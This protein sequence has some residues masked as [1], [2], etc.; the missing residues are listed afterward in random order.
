MYDILLSLYIG[1]YILRYSSS[2]VNLLSWNLFTLSCV[3]VCWE[4]THSASTA[5]AIWIF[6]APHV[7]NSLII[8]LI[9][10][11]V[12]QQIQIFFAFFTSAQ[13]NAYS[14]Q[15][16]NSSNVILHQIGIGSSK[17]PSLCSTIHKICMALQTGFVCFNANCTKFKAAN[18]TRKKIT[19]SSPVH[20]M[21]LTLDICFS[22]HRHFRHL[23]FFPPTFLT[24]PFLSADILD[25]CVF[26][27][28]FLTSAF[29][30]RHFRHLRF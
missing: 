18:F 4:V 16:L 3:V 17:S 10:F 25:I 23:R 26:P 14:N 28:T 6:V 15:L 30:R 1:Q 12:I 8:Q 13:N 29:F 2:S 19:K 20:I 21:F 27:P 9:I 7:C 11:T 24:S 22:F 5:A